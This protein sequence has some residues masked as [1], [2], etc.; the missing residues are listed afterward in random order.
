MTEFLFS[1]NDELLAKSSE[2]SAELQR[3]QTDSGDKDQHSQQLQEQLVLNQSK[4]EHFEAHCK[5]LEIENQ[6]Y[7]E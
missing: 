7:Q 4:L 6:S 2:T 1:R 5:G 3:L